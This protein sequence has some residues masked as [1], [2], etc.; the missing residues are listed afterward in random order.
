MALLNPVQADAKGIGRLLRN[1][2]AVFGRSGVVFGTHGR[3]AR[4]IHS[5]ID[6]GYHIDDGVRVRTRDGHAPIAL[7]PH[8]AVQFSA[9]LSDSDKD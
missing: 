4:R 3:L 5:F 2:Y 7:P 6:Q 9:P 1:R 8:I